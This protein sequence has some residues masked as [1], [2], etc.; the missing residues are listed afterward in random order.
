MT[1]IHSPL[2]DDEAAVLEISAQGMPMIAIGRWQ[3]PIESLLKRGFL[4]DVT[5]YKFNCVITEAGRA[6]MD[7]QEAEDD[8]ALGTA[9][10]RMREMAIAQKS[11]QEM[12]EQCAQVLVKIA[13]ASSVVTGDAKDIAAK[14]WSKVFLDRARELLR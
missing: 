2:T 10:D 6:A 4:K 14:N 9:I 5:G 1:D 13:E 8:R 12:A 7:G 3:K 11:I